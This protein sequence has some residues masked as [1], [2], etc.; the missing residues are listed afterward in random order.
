[1]SKRP[2]F[3]SKQIVLIIVIIVLVISGLVIYQKGVEKGRALEKAENSKK[4]TTS[5]PFN[6]PEMLNR[7]IVGTI[8]KIDN[9]E[10]T[11]QINPGQ[12][13]KVKI[14]NKTTFRGK[15]PKTNANSLKV[16]QRV[17]VNIDQANQEFA[18]R[19]ILR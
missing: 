8:K 3:K 12:E 6:L 14:N 18:S 2:K 19:I 1:M 7:T 15:D 4:Q 13:R 16:N 9:K 10:L 11:I 5:T 17:V